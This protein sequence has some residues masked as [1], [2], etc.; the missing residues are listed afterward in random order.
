VL[1]I[2]IINKKINVD[3]LPKHQLY[4]FTIE[5]VEGAPQPPFGTI[6]N[7]LQDELATLCEY[8]YENLK[9]R[10]IQHSKSPT[11]SLILFVKKNN[12]SF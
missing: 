2:I 3:I 9:K 5:L 6:Y 4:D 1:L 11:S 12:G 7:L 8:I 10:F